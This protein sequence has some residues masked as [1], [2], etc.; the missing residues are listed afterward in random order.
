MHEQK[1]RV[2]ID[3]RNAELP[4]EQR[5][6]T[7]QREAVPFEHCTT[8]CAPYASSAA[9]PIPGLDLRSRRLQLGAHPPRSSEP[10]APDR[11]RGDRGGPGGRG[12]SRDRRALNT[13]L[14]LRAYS[15]GRIGSLRSRTCSVRAE[16]Q[17][18]IYDVAL[19]PIDREYLLSLRP[20][21]CYLRSHLRSGWSR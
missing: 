17:H 16:V 19:G 13:S 12:L 10:N 18:R 9:V 14:I 21:K 2:I 20:R 15:L 3:I 7:A 5:P 1:A 8:L 4:F 11:L 6:L